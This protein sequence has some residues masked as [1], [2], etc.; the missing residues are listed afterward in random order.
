VECR[1]SGR[2]VTGQGSIGEHRGAYPSRR[3]TIGIPEW[4]EVAAGLE[5]QFGYERMR[6]VRTGDY[7]PEK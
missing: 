6:M 3:P 2:G 7:L 4:A 1:E 5:Q